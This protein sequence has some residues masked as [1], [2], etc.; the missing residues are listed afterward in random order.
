MKNLS[1]PSALLTLKISYFISKC[2]FI[3]EYQR[4][5]NS[6]HASNGK[7]IGKSKNKEEECY[8]IEER[9]NW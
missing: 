2:V 5:C 7:A 8:S 1:V 3:Q 4:I 6:A 9:E